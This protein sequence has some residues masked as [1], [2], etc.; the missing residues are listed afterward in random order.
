MS[1]KYYNDRIWFILI[2]VNAFYHKLNPLFKFVN[3]R[4]DDYAMALLESNQITLKDFR[5]QNTSQTINLILFAMYYGL[6]DTFLLILV[7]SPELDV[8]HLFRQICKIRKLDIFFNYLL[9]CK[10]F[11]IFA[12]DH[13]TGSSALH[14]SIECSNSYYALALLD[15]PELSLPNMNVRNKNN[16]TALQIAIDS[17]A[18]LEL[19]NRLSCLNAKN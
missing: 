11:D 3:S 1:V 2:I 19:I 6:L 7:A 13:V 12:V 14:I 15:S 18:P 5:V 17:E 4:N 10:K 16:K 8:A 9:T